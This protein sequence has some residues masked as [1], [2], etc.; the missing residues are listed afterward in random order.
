MADRDDDLPTLL[1][2]ASLCP[3][4]SYWPFP[5]TAAHWDCHINI[6]A[7]HGSFSISDSTAAVQAAD[8]CSRVCTANCLNFFN[9]GPGKV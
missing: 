3:Q 4:E 2:R 9:M 1:P 7:G 6:S 5:S 8:L